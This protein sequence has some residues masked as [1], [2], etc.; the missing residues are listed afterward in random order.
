MVWC[1]TVNVKP[2]EADQFIAHATKLPT[3]SVYGELPKKV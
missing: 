1:L 3:F 2:A